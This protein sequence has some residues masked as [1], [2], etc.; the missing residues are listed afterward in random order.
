[1]HRL[2]I[3]PLFYTKYYLITAFDTLIAKIVFGVFLLYYNA[4]SHRTEA[5]VDMCPIIINICNC[6]NTYTIIHY[7]IIVFILKA[8]LFY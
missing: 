3:F 1:M 2:I 5:F 6:V 7:L 4:V 8:R